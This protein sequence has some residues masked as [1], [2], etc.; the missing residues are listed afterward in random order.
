MESIHSR[1]HNQDSP[2]APGPDAQD[3]AAGLGRSG[4]PWTSRFPSEKR[5][6]SSSSNASLISQQFTTVLSGQLEP[7]VGWGQRWRLC[8]LGLLLNLSEPPCG[9]QEQ[10]NNTLCRVG[11]RRTESPEAAHSLGMAM[12]VPTHST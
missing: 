5:K 9:K 11:E 1:G 8:G 7:R 12:T 2:S 10:L 3:Q 4:P 6:P